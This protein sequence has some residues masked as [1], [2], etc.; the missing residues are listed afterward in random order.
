[1]IK[2]LLLD[3]T[4]VFQT[5]AVHLNKMPFSNPPPRAMGSTAAE[6]WQRSRARDE[7]RQDR[8]MQ[9]SPHRSPGAMVRQRISNRTQPPDTT[10]DLQPPLGAD[11]VTKG[12]RP[13]LVACE[14]RTEKRDSQWGATISRERAQWRLASAPAPLPRRVA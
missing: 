3:A 2:A 13:W 1:M 11:A 9:L 10:G 7:D 14:T 12:N 6:R 5:E 8:T 4:G